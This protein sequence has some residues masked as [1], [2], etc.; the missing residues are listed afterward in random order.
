MDQ[1]ASQQVWLLTP[2]SLFK[3]VPQILG[4]HLNNIGKLPSLLTQNENM[5]K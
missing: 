3:Q 2:E 1:E 4:P 5:M